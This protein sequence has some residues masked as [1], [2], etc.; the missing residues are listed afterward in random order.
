MS[1]HSIVTESRSRSRP[2]SARAQASSLVPKR[3]FEVTNGDSSSICITKIQ[4]NKCKV[5]CTVNSVVGRVVEE[6]LL[7]TSSEWGVW[8]WRVNSISEK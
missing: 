4:Y 5:T 8:I 7:S 3:R 1:E 6:I 2:A